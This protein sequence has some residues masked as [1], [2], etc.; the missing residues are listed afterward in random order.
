MAHESSR[1]SD[2]F[3]SALGRDAWAILAMTLV[4]ALLLFI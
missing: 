2:M 1:R 3:R 4:L